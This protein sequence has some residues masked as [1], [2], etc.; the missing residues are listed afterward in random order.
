MEHTFSHLVYSTSKN[1]QSLITLAL[2]I[3]VFA[4]LTV[5]VLLQLV[6]TV[7]ARAIFSMVSI[8]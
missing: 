7:L 5:I 1:M 8:Y 6:K 3:V 4:V 2:V